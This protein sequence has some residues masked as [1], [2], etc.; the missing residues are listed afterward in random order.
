MEVKLAAIRFKITPLAWLIAAIVAGLTILLTVRR[1]LSK[2]ALSIA[3]TQLGIRE[4]GNNTGKDVEKYL[5]SVGLPGGHPWCMAFVVWCF[6]QSAASLKTKSPLL[7]TGG[8]LDQWNRVPAKYKKS[9]PSVGSIF[10]MSTGGGKGHTGII[11]KVFPNGT[12]TAIEGNS[13][14]NRSR[15]GVKVVTNT[16]STSDKTIVGYI[17]L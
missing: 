1:M 14:S 12:F 11:T 4:T 9:A 15:E 8:V 5:K 10:I 3:A 6:E 2:K 7:R 16:R 13:N 17:T